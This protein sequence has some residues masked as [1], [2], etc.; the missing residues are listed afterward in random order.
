[1][2]AAT[3]IRLA[4]PDAEGI[5]LEATRFTSY[6]ACGIPFVVGGEIPGGVEGLVARSPEEHRRRGIDLRTNHQALAID[7]A[8]GEVEVLA[9]HS[10]DILHVGYDELMIATG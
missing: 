6:S 4:R 10:G 5:V 7:T 3:R 9:E 2:S 1:M 8:R